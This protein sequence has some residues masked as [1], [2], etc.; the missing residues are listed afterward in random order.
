MDEATFAFGSFRLLPAQRA[1]LEDGKPLRLGS[2]ALDI[3]IAL[4][5]RAGETIRKD[6][7]IA[8]TWPD[9][10]VDEGALRVHV[11]ALRKSLGDG[12]AGKRYIANI[13]GRGYSFVAPVAR[14]RRQP[15]TDP[16]DGAAVGGNLPAPLTRIIGRDVIITALT[17]Q[18][19]RH[20]FLTIVGPGGIGKT[21]V[22]VKVAENAS[23][24][25]RDGVWFAGL[26][27]LPDP[28]LVASALGTVLGLALPAVNP[29]AGLT[30]WLRDKQALIVLDSCEHV[31]D[32]TAAM[33][34]AILKAAA[35]VSILATSREPLRAE[36][37]RLHRLRSLE[38]PPRWDDLTPDGALKYPA[39][40]LFNER[41]SATMDGFVLGEADVAPVLEICHRLD[42]VP[43]ALELAAARV[44]VFGVKGL[45][46]HLDDRFA[47]L[48][49]GR[50]TALPR[51]QTLRA[52]MDWSYDVLLETEQ[53]VLRRISVFQGDFTIEAA[54]A[55]ASDERIGTA[56]VFDAVADLS[57]KSL[58]STD[59]SSD[60]IYH[61]LLDTT[62]AYALEKLTLSAE[63]PS[64]AFRHAEYY[65]DLLTAAALN[66]ASE[67]GAPS[68]SSRST[69]SAPRSPGVSGRTGMRRSRS[70]WR[71]LLRR[72][73]C[74]CP[75]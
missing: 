55:V 19:V 54:A 35:G 29:A 68:N 11:A 34:E 74:K 10:V 25:Y 61:R 30:G 22:A 59:I 8:K 57:A 3:L 4:V 50:R 32:A 67:D 47:F 60:V 37:E 7:L 65:R 2:R 46:A 41:A 58:V 28:D 17:T 64:V 16:P 45:A 51:H 52:A 39:V 72:C 21:T 13:P 73:G 42:G 12:R 38:V 26:A 1:L 33:A 6:E 36:G 5:E 56:D 44:D 15:A 48:T 62:R 14:E 27:S 63:I 18:L 24:S 75:C 40:Q 70:C 53:I 43:L 69:I 71:R 49:S 23:M 31:I 66:N 20:R 9:A